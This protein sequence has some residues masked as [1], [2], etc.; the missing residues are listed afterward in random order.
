MRKKSGIIMIIIVWLVTAI[1]SS[2]SQVISTIKGLVF[3]DYYYNLNN[4]NSAEENQNAFQF[5]RIYFTFE[6]NISQNIKIRFRLEAK[7]EPFGSSSKLHPFVKHAYLEWANLI[8]HHKLYF[9]IAETN[10]FKNAE[11]YWGYRSIEK[12]ILDLNKLNS[13]ADMGIALK[14]DLGTVAHHWLTI[15]NGTGYGSSEVDKYKKIGY[16]LWLTPVNGLLLEGYFEYEKQDPKT[17][18]LKPARDYFHSSGYYMMKGF[19]GYSS[20]GITV[21]AEAFIRTN[22]ESG[23][24]DSEGRSRIDVKH[25]G[26]SIF[27]SWITP[28]PKIKIFGRYDYYDPNIDDK[29]Y[30]DRSTNGIDDEHTLFIGGLDFSPKENVHIMPNIMISHYTQSG[31]DSDVTARITLYYMFDS[32]KITI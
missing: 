22:Q 5:R 26:F 12:T 1:G 2:Q 17:G 31:K 16:A 25:H 28:I 14:G 18:S 4:H 32:G 7:H 20:P 9:G 30:V 21:G 8:P 3:A 10:A 23:S 15:H 24:T 29:V 6:N 19:L 27:G 11:R 13:S